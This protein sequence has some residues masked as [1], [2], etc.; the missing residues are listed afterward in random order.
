MYAN[1]FIFIQMLDTHT[2]MFIAYLNS[3][4]KKKNE[5]KLVYINKKRG[6][7]P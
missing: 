7:T 1:T 5:I 6:T 3:R 2:F 4:F